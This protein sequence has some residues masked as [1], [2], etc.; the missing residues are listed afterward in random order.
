MSKRVGLTAAAA[1]GISFLSY[2]VVALDSA[3][4]RAF[5]VR[6]DPR[7]AAG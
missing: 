6:S 3:W 5:L 2:E 1:H 7:V 4:I